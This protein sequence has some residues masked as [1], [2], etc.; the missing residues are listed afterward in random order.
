[1]VFDR[2]MKGRILE[3]FALNI[4]PFVVYNWGI[5]NYHKGGEVVE[6]SYKFLL[7]PNGEQINLIGRD[8]PEPIRL[9][10]SCKTYGFANSGR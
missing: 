7:Y 2:G 9:G 3:H 8:T 1:M 6:Y 4:R 5:T 10:R